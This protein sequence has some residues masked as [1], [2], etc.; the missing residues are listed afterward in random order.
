MYTT[1]MLKS[2]CL[3]GSL[4]LH[5]KGKESGGGTKSLDCKI[6]ESTEAPAL[7]ES[8]SSPT[9]TQQHSWQV[10]TDIENTERHARN[11]KPFKQTQGN[12]AFTTEKSR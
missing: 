1:E 9:D 10:S 4:Q 7:E 2:I 11:E 6:E 12:Y 3:L 8:S 5:R